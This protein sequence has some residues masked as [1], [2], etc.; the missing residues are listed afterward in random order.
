[1]RASVENL[2]LVCSIAWRMFDLE[3]LCSVVSANAWGADCSA[4]KMLLVCS[5]A[6]RMSDLECINP[7]IP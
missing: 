3:C 6:W 7:T 2:L 5:I 4:A 1:M